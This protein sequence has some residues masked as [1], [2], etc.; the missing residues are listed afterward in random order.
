MPTGGTAGQIIIKVDSTNYNV[1]WGNLTAG[2][3]GF[4]PTG[5]IAA[6]NVQGAIAELDAEKVGGPGASTDQSLVRWNGTGGFSVLSSGVVLDGSDNITGAATITEIG[7][8]SCRERVC[9]Y[10]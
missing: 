3:V 6:T 1:A 8:A 10:V 5:G 4:T 9:Q 7:R 2:I